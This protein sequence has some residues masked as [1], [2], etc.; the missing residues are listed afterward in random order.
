[1]AA[2][3][4]HEGLGHACTALL[5]GTRSGLLTTVAWSSGVDSRLVAAGG[6]LA[7]LA[8]A[9]LFWIA[10]RQWKT[11]SV[12]WRYCLLLGVAFNLLDG[13]GY[14]LFSGLT[15]FG[16][17]ARVIA[18]LPP[19]WLWRVALVVLGIAAY[20]GAALLVGTGLV[21]Y[22]G[23]PRNELARLRKLT[24]VPYFSS[25]VLASAAGSLNPIGI[26]LLW[27]SALPATAGGH[28]GLVW[29]I[30]A[31]PHGVVPERRSQAIARDYVWIA[32]ALLL[33]ML[34][35]FVLGRGI[36]LHR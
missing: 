6:T 24:L 14:F 30:Y 15:D 2:D 22:V 8:A 10:L 26:A 18:G 23:I 32:V 17:W 20:Y 36:T 31:I 35:V 5:T 11:T 4:I 1:M 21:R 28:S 33:S 27:Q 3:V 12:R 9:L 16:D 25:V 13:T 34:F 29:L 19:H 7:N